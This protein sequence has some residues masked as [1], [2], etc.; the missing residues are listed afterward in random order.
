VADAPGADDAL[1]DLAQDSLVVRPV[2]GGASAQPEIPCPLLDPLLG[3][4]QLQCP[5]PLAPLVFRRPGV[6]QKLL[7]RAAMNPVMIS[8]ITARFSNT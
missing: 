7:G 1:H 6:R 5:P 4:S 2:L 3:P 8:I